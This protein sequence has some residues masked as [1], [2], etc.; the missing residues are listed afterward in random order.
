MKEAVIVSGDSPY[1]Q[2]ICSYPPQLSNTLFNT[3]SL[4]YGKG[5]KRLRKML[6]SRDWN[7]GYGAYR[8]VFL[9]VL[10]IKKLQFT[11]SAR[12]YQKITLTMQAAHRVLVDIVIIIQSSALT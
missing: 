11:Q 9:S 4:R 10:Q 1:P 5:A 2:I 6:R 3:R 7:Q 8:K 12:V